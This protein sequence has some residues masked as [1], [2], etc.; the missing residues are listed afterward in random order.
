MLLK[1][2]QQQ[3]T[4]MRKSLNLSQHKLSVLAGLSGNA[5]FRMEKQAHKINP[6]RAKAVADVLGCEL[7]DIFCVSDSFCTHSNEKDN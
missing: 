6:L 3:L 5:V 4:E 2:K 7:A 1:V